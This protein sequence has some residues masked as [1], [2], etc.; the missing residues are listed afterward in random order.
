MFCSNCGKEIQPDAKFCPY[1]GT[2]I[3]IESTEK[4]SDEHELTITRTKQDGGGFIKIAVSVDGKKLGK[5]KRGESIKTSVSEGYHKITATLNAQSKSLT[6]IN[7]GKPIIVSYDGFDVAISLP[8]GAEGYVENK[9]NAEVVQSNTG[10]KGQKDNPVLAF[11]ATSAYGNQG[12]LN[13]YID[14]MDFVYKNGDKTTYK[15]SDIGDYKKN[16]SGLAIY[17][18]GKP[19]TFKL[20]RGAADDIIIFLKQQTPNRWRETHPESIFTKRF[21]VIDQV[22]VNEKYGTFCIKSGKNPNGPTYRIKDI[23]NY[24]IQETK[25]DGGDVLEGALIGGALAGRRGALAGALLQP[26]GRG[27]IGKMIFRATVKDG[28]KTAM[29]AACL[30]NEDVSENSS[31]YAYYRNQAFELQSIIENHLRNK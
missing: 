20:P 15:F 3:Q 18:N 31:K 10:A 30:M 22:L 23:L 5:L 1:C 9:S 24:E 19:Y 17:M 13:V 25:A 29:V 28:S 8:D 12:K 21:G 16:F 11:D 7:T 6:F 26:T 2:S 4:N 27:K 14:H